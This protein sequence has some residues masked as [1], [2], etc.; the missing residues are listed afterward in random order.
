MEQQTNNFIQPLF[1]IGLVGNVSHGKSL[2]IKA[3]TNVETFRHSKE[4][5]RGI[6]IKIGYTN[7][8]IFK[9]EKCPEPECY[10][11]TNSKIKN[12]QCGDCGSASKLVQYFSFIDCPGHESLM[13]TM[14]SGAT[15]MDY[16]I[17]LIDGSQKCPQPQTIEHL[18]AL[19]ILQIKK[20]IIIQNKLDLVG[21]NKALEQYNDIKNF[22][23]GTCAEFAPVIPFSAQ[24]KYNVDILCEYIVKYFGNVERL[25][26][27]PKMNIIRSFDVNKPGCEISNLKG[28]VLGGSLVTGK[29]NVGDTIEIRPGVV[30]SQNLSDPANKKIVWKPLRTEIVSM[31]T[32]MDQ[33]MEASPGGLVGICTN[34]DP[35]QTRSD[36]MVG[37]IVGFP[38]SMPD[39]F[40]EITAKCM[41]MKQSIVGG[42]KIKKPMQGDELLLNI[43]SKPVL[44]IIKKIVKSN[45]QL[46]LKWPCC[47]DI[48]DKF[49]ISSKSSNSWRLI[50]MGEFIKN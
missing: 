26:N 6:T 21:G 3:L 31:Q 38:D 35:A 8:K 43:S 39:V 44:S 7:C 19:E 28:G 13:S 50:G 45:Y 11:S 27:K 17:L 37:Q 15:I 9:C 40:M 30:L 41:F 12:C 36:K 1:N 18:A 34:L 32:D 47:M 29:F 46:E 20:I 25:I 4:K 14:L 49:S 48:G 22:V 5:E 33:I 16:A 23:K 2:T 42:T 24:K 10:F